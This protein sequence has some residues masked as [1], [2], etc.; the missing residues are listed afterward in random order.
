MTLTG[1]SGY[2]CAC[3]VTDASGNVRAKNESNRS[4]YVSSEPAYDRLSKENITLASAAKRHRTA[5]ES[6]LPR[7][8]GQCAIRYLGTVPTRANIYFVK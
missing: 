5:R 7:R 6:V 2:C 3:A 8:G 4:I 1:W